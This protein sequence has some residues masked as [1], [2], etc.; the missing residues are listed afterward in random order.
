[1]GKTPFLNSYFSSYEFLQRRTVTHFLTLT[2]SLS[3]SRCRVSQGIFISNQPEATDQLKYFTPCAIS[4]SVDAEVLHARL[5]SRPIHPFLR[6]IPGFPI[7]FAIVNR[8]GVCPN[9]NVLFLPF[10]SSLSLSLSLYLFFSFTS[11]LIYFPN[12][13]SPFA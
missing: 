12:S 6:C 2:P 7:P 13:P 10:S 5:T 9:V 1:M 11:T 8:E 4:A 3:L